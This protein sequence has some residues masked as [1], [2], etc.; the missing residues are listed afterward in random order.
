MRSL[1]DVNVLIALNDAKHVHHLRSVDWFESHGDSGWASC[2]ITQNGVL[3]IMSQ[4]AYPQT[5]TV[6]RLLA[7]LDASFATRYHEF[8]P[9]D[10]SLT[11]VSLFR[12][13]RI[14]GHRQLTDLYLLGLAVRHGGRLVTLDARIA[15][16]AVIGA[17]PGNLV[18]LLD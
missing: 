15:V 7:R 17:R 12:A 3:R 18:S 13:D 2:P 1:L 8:W 10:V 6:G 4:P 16:N 11:D 14:H 5:Q 9:D